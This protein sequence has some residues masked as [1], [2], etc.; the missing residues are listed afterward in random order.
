M[1]VL[2]GEPFTRY[3][4]RALYPFAH[5]IIA[6]E[7][8]T[9]LAVASASPDGH[10]TDDTLS[11][12][13]AFRDTEDPEGKLVI[14]T[15]EDEGHPNGFWPGEKNEMSQAY[16]RRATGD[17]L[18]QVD[19]DE[20]YRAEDLQRV[21]GLLSSDDTITT[22]SFFQRT[23]WGSPEFHVDGPFMRGK[24]TGG[25]YHRLFRWGAGYRYVDHRPPTVLDA[26]GRDLREGHWLDG[27][28][29][30]TQGIDLYHYSLLFDFQVLQKAGYYDRQGW[31]GRG[32]ESDW[33]RRGWLKLERPFHVHN[34]HR[35]VAWLERF[36]GEHPEQATL[37][38]ADLSA[39][40][41]A[42]A[43]RDMTDVECLLRNPLF[44]LCRMLMRT[45]PAPVDMGKRGRCRWQSVLSSLANAF[46][47][48]WQRRLAPCATGNAGGSGA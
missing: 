47:R 6:V 35:H 9:H 37:M 10:S 46:E 39:G 3:A 14:V 21:C 11:V 7:G 17:W 34:V 15:A 25:E 19:S 30:H 18:W 1:I 24:M 33:A 38:W 32:D 28:C 45:W 4:L 36:G 26:Q 2:N 31:D 5:Q 16:A 48:L 44:R 13:R 43:V 23:F 8:A 29:M 40:A 20:F 27:R 12:L 22:V 41:S 42:V